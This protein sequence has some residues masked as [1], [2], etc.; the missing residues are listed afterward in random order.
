MKHSF[1]LLPS[2]SRNWS[3][4][5]A[6]I[7]RGEPSS[8]GLQSPSEQGSTLTNCVTACVTAAGTWLTPTGARERMKGVRVPVLHGK[9]SGLGFSL[10]SCTYLVCLS[11]PASS[12]CSTVLTLA[13][14]KYAFWTSSPQWHAKVSFRTESWTSS[15][16]ENGLGFIRIYPKRTKCGKASARQTFRVLAARVWELG[17]H[18]NGVVS[19]STS[20]LSLPSLRSP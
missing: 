15:E 9:L 8:V 18:G 16:L 4:V 13:L 6:E 11:S 5:G 3:W 14:F 19:S 12:L 10:C 2:A 20:E 17:T 1:H 7:C